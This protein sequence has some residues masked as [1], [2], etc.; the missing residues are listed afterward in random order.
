MEKPERAT[1][2]AVSI[3]LITSFF[4]RTLEPAEELL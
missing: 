1:V 2:R 3:P 4:T